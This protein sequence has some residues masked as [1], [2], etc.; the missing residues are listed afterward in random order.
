MAYDKSTDLNDIQKDVLTTALTNN[1]KISK[2]NQLGTT[3]KTIIKAINELNGFLGTATDQANSAT[4][5]ANEA[6]ESIEITKA[7][8]QETIKT[9]VKEVIVTE[10]V[11]A[12]I[13]YNLQSDEFACQNGQ[14]VFALSKVPADK[15]DI[16]FYVN[17]IKYMKTD[18]QY[19]KS[20]NT[21]QWLNAEND[22]S[23]P[24]AFVLKS[25]DYVSIVYMAK[26]VEEEN[27]NQGE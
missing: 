12:S 13:N 5:T 25:T 17:G 9:V 14:T 11:A 22:D 18:Y 24:N 27:Q 8:L 3:A 10:G 4:A 7:E 6:K 16:L 21:V 20:S 2:I 23:H 15:G 26:P 1:S 19:D